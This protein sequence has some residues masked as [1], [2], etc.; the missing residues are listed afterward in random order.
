MQPSRA[1]AHEAYN[2]QLLAMELPQRQVVVE[3]LGIEAL[4]IEA[5]DEI[6]GTVGQN[7]LMHVMLAILEKLPPDAQEG[8]K[9]LTEESRG[10]E[11]EALVAQHISDLPAF[12]TAES[13]KALAEFKAIHASL[14]P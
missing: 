8:F 5:Q 3:E 9:A 7:I 14:A 10:E 1:S 11:A 4:P 2:F 6:I 12:I 13:R